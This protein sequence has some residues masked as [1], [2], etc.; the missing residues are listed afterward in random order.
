[1]ECLLVIDMQNG[2]CDPRGSLPSLGIELEGV[3]EAIEGCTRAVSIA[4]GVDIPIIF[5][6]HQYRAGY[7]D[8]GRNF[9]PHRESISQL[10]GLL[11][12]SWDAAVIDGLDLKSSDVVIEKTRYDSFLGTPLD[13]LLRGLNVD[14]LTVCGVVTNVCVESTV[15]S[16]FM[17]DYSVNLLSDACAGQ[18][19]GLHNDSLRIIEACGFAATQQ[20]NDYRPTRS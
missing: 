1:M 16:A 4:R 13:P 20:S 8:A 12:G 17:R 6:R 15:R 2:F 14:V 11:A 10:G 19:L 18:T 5:T 7:I 3:D 9:E